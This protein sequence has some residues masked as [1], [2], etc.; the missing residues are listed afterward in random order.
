MWRQ[1]L[2]Y[3]VKWEGYRIEHN[4]WEY[5]DN[6]NNA[7][8]AVA[9]FH[10]THPGAPRRIRVMAFGT[11]PFHPVPLA[12]TLS[13]CSSRRRGDCKGNTLTLHASPPSTP[14][15]VPPSTPA[16]THPSSRAH[17]HIRKPDSHALPTT[18]ASSSR[19]PPLTVQSL[20]V[21]SCHIIGL[22]A[23]LWT[24]CIS[25]FTCIY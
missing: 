5:S 20:Y 13:R 18:V 12:F 10:S 17:L 19:P 7:A 9:E 22:S 15:L 3:L 21:S 4:T 14:V 8:E 24:L 25:L 16:L 23:L 1:K 2:Q 11:I 6:L